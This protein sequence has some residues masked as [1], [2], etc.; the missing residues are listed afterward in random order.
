MNVVPWL[1]FGGTEVANAERVLGYLRAG[2]GGYGWNVST[3]RRASGSGYTNLYEDIYTADAGAAW[4]LLCHCDDLPNSVYASPVEDPAPWY[5]AAKPASEEFLGVLPV[6]I[7]RRPALAR[8]VGTTG[9][10]AVLGP[11]ELGAQFVEVTALL[12]A[13]TGAGMDWGERWLTDALTGGCDDLADLEMIL[14]CGDGVRSLLDTGLVDAPVFA[15]EGDMASCRMRSVS[16]QLA[17]ESP[18]HFGPAESLF[19]ES[20]VAGDL[21]TGEATTEEWA[22]GG[23]VVFTVTAGSGAVDGLVL[24]VATGACDAEP[25]TLFEVTASVPAGRRL[26]IDP[27]T[28]TVAIEH[29]AT[30][31]SEGGLDALEYSGMFCW[32]EIGPCSTVCVSA[33]VTGEPGIQASVVAEFYPREL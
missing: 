33:E 26:V 27:R 7:V 24:R 6:S 3:V 20:L 32:P 8:A 10:G 28:Q 1:C 13:T 22:G 11:L 18:W 31:L 23:A 9:R 15:D 19:A 21:Y 12:I 17:S 25:G 14:A 29:V 5:V 30:G 16:F 2:L 4:E